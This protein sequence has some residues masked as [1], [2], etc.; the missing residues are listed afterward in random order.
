MSDER[1]DLSGSHVSQQEVRSNPNPIVPPTGSRTFP[2][3]GS[4][5]T[6]LLM[7]G[8]RQK[9]H[10]VTWSNSSNAHSCKG[11]RPAAHTDSCLECGLNTG[12][13]N[14]ME[15]FVNNN[16]QNNRKTLF[17]GWGTCAMNLILLSFDFVGRCAF[18]LFEKLCNF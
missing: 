18:Q 17:G 15:L 4:S 7:E 2:A 6:L 11:I 16:L 5:C 12:R 8:I 3:G 9:H 13:T 14:M 10:R 1:A